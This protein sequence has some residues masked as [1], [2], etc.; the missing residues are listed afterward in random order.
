MTYEGGVNSYG[1]IFKITPS[2]T[3]TMLWSF[4]AGSDG[5]EPYGDLTFGPDGT[6]YGLTYEGGANGAGA[7]IE[8]N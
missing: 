5:N 2:G 4:G 3:E 1:T 8:Y 7:V 6:L